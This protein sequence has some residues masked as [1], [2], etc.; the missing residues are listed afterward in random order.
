MMHL[1]TSS[2]LIRA[3]STMG[4]A[5]TFIWAIYSIVCVPLF[6]DWEEIFWSNYDSE[7]VPE[8]QEEADTEASPN[9]GT[10]QGSDAGRAHDIEE[11]EAG[12]EED[13]EEELKVE[14][15][16]LCVSANEGS[17]QQAFENE[18]LFITE[19]WIKSKAVFIKF[20]LLFLVEHLIFLVPLID[21]HVAI[22]SR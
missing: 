9:R 22:R 18:A 7:R 3:H 11:Q 16:T 10:L 14:E 21:L 2:F 12:G 4:R 13:E 8:F 1:T 15:E 17:R 6:I 20:I 5:R 19:A